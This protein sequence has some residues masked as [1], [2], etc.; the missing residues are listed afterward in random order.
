M[1]SEEYLNRYI[2]RIHRE[3]V[4]NFQATNSVELILAN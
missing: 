1:Y 2:F 4:R 3:F